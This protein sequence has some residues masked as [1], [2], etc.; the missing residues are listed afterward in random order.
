MVA[1]SAV[2]RLKSLVPFRFGQGTQTTTGVQVVS[3]HGKLL[4]YC[5]IPVIPLFKE[6]LPMAVCCDT[7][8]IPES[9]EF[10][11]K[12]PMLPV[13]IKAFTKGKTRLKAEQTLPAL[14][15]GT[16][17]ARWCRQPWRRSACL[18]DAG[19][20]QHPCRASRRIDRRT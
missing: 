10:T 14:S 5:E 19:R 12:P 1:P 9:L 11:A 17:A 6:Y 18:V 3:Q 2:S 16:R 7:A 13:Y 4:S 15:A 20:L 8:R